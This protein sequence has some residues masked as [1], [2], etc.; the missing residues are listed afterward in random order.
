MTTITDTITGRD[1]VTAEPITDLLAERWSPRAF[2]ASHEISD[3]EVTALLEAARWAPSATNRQPRRFIAGRR[4][5]PVFETLVGTLKDSNRVW[6]PRASLFVLG[7]SVRRTPEGEPVK[8][9]DYDLGQ[10]I[11]HLTV[12]A[13]ALGLGVR[14][15]GG[16]HADV[17]ADALGIEE[18]SVPLVLT[19]VGRRGS[20][21][22]L[23]AESI[24]RETTPRARLDLDEI[25]LR[26]E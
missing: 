3:A 7:I 9:A 13:Q 4:G 15:M 20:H 23:D 24:R 26:R 2:D 25:V 19:A 14:Q 21:D 22:G 11:A 8:F 6:A 18:P 16:F 5:S 17:A 1:A 10:S 12:Q